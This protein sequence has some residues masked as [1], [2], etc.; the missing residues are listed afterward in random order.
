MAEY[1]PHPSGAL[2]DLFASQRIPFQGQRL[3]M[4]RVVFLGLDANYDPELSSYPDFFE[5]ILE[6][7]HDGVAFW[8]RHGVHHP[9]LLPEYPLAKN[10]GGVP[11]HRRFQAMGLSAEQ[12]DCI[13]FVELLNVPTTGRTQ[14]TIFWR[15]FDADYATTLEHV[16]SDGRSRLVVLSGSVLTAIREAKR[17]LGLFRTFPDR[18][19][20]GASV[21]VGECEFT[22]FKHFSSAIG[23]S[24]L[25]QMGRRIRCFCEASTGPVS[26]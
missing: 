21:R 24:E 6:Y 26:D 7:H 13:A 11:Y 12:A 8:K 14:K 10:T 19:E 15:L 20:I 4:A 9:F 1:G 25:R 22:R 5:R 2:R 16:L 23:N 17:Q 3:E 18:L